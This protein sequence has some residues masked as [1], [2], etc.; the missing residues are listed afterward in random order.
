MRKGLR[1]SGRYHSRYM[2]GLPGRGN[3]AFRSVALVLPLVVIRAQTS[4][5]GYCVGSLFAFGATFGS[6]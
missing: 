6:H 3:L 1:A 5:N 4:R 2:G